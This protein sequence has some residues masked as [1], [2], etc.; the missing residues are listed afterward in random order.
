[1][2]KKACCLLFAAILLLCSSA[3]VRI[4]SIRS[5]DITEITVYTAQELLD[6]INSNTKIILGADA[7]NLSSVTNTNN[8]LV[9][10]QT[11]AD[12]YIV[13]A[14]K[15][16]MITGNAEIIIDDLYA[17]VLSFENCSNVILE[18][19]TVGHS[20]SSDT[21]ICEGAVID[22]ENCFNFKIQACNLY[23]C[24]AIG[25]CSYDTKNL[26]VQDTSI[27]DCSFSGIYLSSCP[28]VH[29]KNSYLY[30]I[31]IDNPYGAVCN[32]R[33]SV[34]NFQGCSIY[35]NII[36]EEGSVIFID[37]EEDDFSRVTFNDSTIKN[38]LFPDLINA[39]AQHITFNN[40]EFGGNTGNLEHDFAVFHNCIYSD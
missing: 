20:E 11:Y 37:D 31:N 1:M 14:V 26:I 5:A 27:Y 40:C 2:R 17:D 35:N 33:N 34:I 15:N 9:A 8:R 29:V 36:P 30:N 39:Q 18:G 22:V 23:G 28:E 24:G 3:C 4:S 21:Y 12:G 25:V 6:A 7:Y 38:N 16:L 32:I 19:L 10:K 13:N